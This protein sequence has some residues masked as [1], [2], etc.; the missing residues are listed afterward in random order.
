MGRN[1]KFLKIFKKILTNPKGYDIITMS[2]GQENKKERQNKMKYYTA[3]ES[4]EISALMT[5]AESDRLK[6]SGF[7]T[8]VLNEIETIGVEITIDKETIIDERVIDNNS[9]LAD[10]IVSY[11]EYIASHIDGTEN[12]KI[13]ITIV[14]LLTGEI[15]F[16]AYYEKYNDGESTYMRED[17]ARKGLREII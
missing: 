13:S 16:D 5:L 2:K 9:I 14:N 3:K 4:N 17:C 11:D 8:K 7:A 6:W 10:Y 1:K 15:I 12:F